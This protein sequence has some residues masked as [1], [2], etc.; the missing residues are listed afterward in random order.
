MEIEI[1][2]YWNVET[3]YYVFNAV[4]AF[5]GG[6]GFEGL[7]KTV[8]LM[9]VGVGIFAYAGNK[10]L[11]MAKWFIQALVFVS[12]LNLPIARVGITDKAGL[13]PPKVVDNVPFALAIISYGTNLVFGSLTSGYETVFGV[14]ESL[15]LQKGDVG[16]GHRIL[17]SVNRA[18]ISDPKLKADLMQ[19]IK[20][21]TIYDV[22]DG[23]IDAKRDIVE[24][25]DTWNTI[26]SNTSP[27]RFV[28]Y[29]TMSG[30][31]K[32][33]PCT[34][35]AGILKIR[36]EDGLEAARAYYGKQVFSRAG[37]DE[38]ADSMYVTAVGSSYEWIL[39]NSTNASTALR[40]SMF[41]NIWKEAGTE[42]PALLNDPARV[43]EV[44]AMMS[45]AQAAR[46]AAGANA[47][48]SILAQETLPHM[49][50]WIEAILYSMFPIILILVVVSTA[51]GAKQ[52][53][54]G[55]IMA[56]AWIGMWPVLFAVVNHLSMMHLKYKSKALGLESG[57]GVSFQLSD[58]FDA[59]LTDEQA[60]IGYMVLLVPFLSA[61][62]I[63]MGQGAIMSVAD[64]MAAGFSSAVHGAGYQGAIGNHSSGQVGLDTASVN[65]TSMH[66][67][68]NNMSL[69]GGGSTVGMGNG[70]S[71]TLT[72]NGRSLMT[73]AR[74]QMIRKMGVS[75][76]LES[77]VNEAIHRTDITSSGQSLTYRSGESSS[78]ND[79]VGADRTRG[80][81]QQNGVNTSQTEQ[82]GESGS[83][84]RGQSVSRVFR[85]ASN[86]N[87][88]TSQND[89]L[90]ANLG[91]GGGG[92]GGR[93]ASGGG[94][95][96]SSS[97]GDNSSESRVKR[98]LGQTL[99]QTNAGLGI[100]INKN[101]SATHSRDRSEGNQ[102]SHDENA[103]LDT[104]FQSSGQR[105]EQN[106]SGLQ[107]Q[108]NSRVA[109]DAVY[110]RTND[111]SEVNDVLDR[112]EHGR[113]DRSHR[114]NT[115]SFNTSRDLYEDPAFIEAVANRNGMST[116]RFLN[117]DQAQIW[118][119]VDSY[120]QEKG[121]I[122]SATKLNTS[123]YTGQTIPA[124]INGL[125][126]ISD[127]EK[128]TIPNNIKGLHST[129][130]AQTGA[131]SVSPV[132]VDTS[133][134]SIVG[135]SRSSVE[136]QLDSGN[137]GS[138]PARTAAL[139]ENT[140]AWA[141]HGREIG[142]GLANPAY[143]NQQNLANDANDFRAK[144]VDLALG[145]DGTSDGTKL[146]ENMKRATGSSPII[147][148]ETKK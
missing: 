136:G 49:R 125:S 42:L 25:T 143:V 76:G 44:N 113:G 4:S 79:I 96:N 88:N 73:Q 106:G 33:V 110:S 93:N 138:I 85:D 131:G 89:S 22:R 2:T 122:N 30:Q 111:R 48:I 128:S 12:I 61:G 60:L 37:T 135:S 144:L 92:G 98:L 77:G 80:N 13:E 28:T 6:A 103:R 68:D 52:I 10:Q 78:A 31:P 123:G 146:N 29:D 65:T 104:N 57:D 115:N 82:G 11:E 24:G 71:M 1:Q 87:S 64:R 91:L 108:Q 145:G 47:S 5:M 99:G 97:G 32:T 43:A 58:V 117:Q 107:S 84:N 130:S 26:F 81:F 67:Y 121:I 114:S 23:E 27:A 119:M 14:P 129:R 147:N 142:K 140:G 112:V 7:M 41:N 20:E 102:H 132:S 90:N 34:E 51:Q 62:I 54:V 17:K 59:T 40:Q 18:S 36:V 101:Y 83:H 16:F 19:F 148:S 55:Y 116:N 95:Q 127:D 39:N 9:A 63:K 56:L 139:D 133:T 109:K 105:S 8:F 134:P 75:S 35:A 94:G 46:Q 126:Q 72:P 66:K 100:R 21:C 70:D 45:S 141:S 15:G 137:K 69:T 74:N 50:N 38:I 3:L 124:G 53:L 118:S 86:F 120:A